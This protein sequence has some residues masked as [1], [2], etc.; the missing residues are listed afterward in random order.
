MKACKS[1]HAVRDHIFYNASLFYEFVWLLILEYTIHTSSRLYFTQDVI[2]LYDFDIFPGFFFF[3]FSN[4]YLCSPNMNVL[5]L[6]EDIYNLHEVKSFNLNVSGRSVSIYTFQSCQ[7]L[8]RH[9]IILKRNYYAF[10]M[11]IEN[12]LFFC[13]FFYF[14]WVIFE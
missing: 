13:F 12:Y 2:C 8:I 14:S 1:Y 7:V 5:S 3:S 4:I 9:F 6:S 11:S 10:E